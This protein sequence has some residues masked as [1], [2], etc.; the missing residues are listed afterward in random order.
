MTVDE[1]TEV[2]CYLNPR[3]NRGYLGTLSQEQLE[4][5][6]VHLR[7]LRLMRMN[8]SIDLNGRGA[9]GT[10]LRGRTAAQATAARA[11]SPVPA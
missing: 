6:L 8:D 9:Q 2:I 11:A 1:C 4:A 3:L 7:A 5:Y 10:W